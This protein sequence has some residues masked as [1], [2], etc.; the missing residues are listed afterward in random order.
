MEL[1]FEHYQLHRADE[2]IALARDRLKRQAEIIAELSQDGHDVSEAQKLLG[3]FSV[4][5]EA[6]TKHRELIAEHI[7]RLEQRDAG[8]YA[9]TDSEDADWIVG[10]FS[11]SDDSG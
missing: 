10:H 4:T 8:A 3:I 11:A 9:A 2:H 5:L 7:E 1:A 6:M